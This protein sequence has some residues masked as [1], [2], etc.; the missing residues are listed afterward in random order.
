MNRLFRNISSN[1][2]AAGVHAVLVLLV[3]PVV[4][5]RLGLEHY[6]VWIVVQTIGYFLG[7][8]DLGLSDAQVRQ[9]A[10]LAARGDHQAVA[11]LHGTVLTLFAG[12][13]LLVV[14]L[15]AAI[16]ALPTAALLDIP[17]SARDSYGLVV[18]L[19]GLASAAA[20]LDVGFDGLF[21][22]HQ[23]YD[24]M[25]LVNLVVAVV[26]ALLVVGLLWLG[27]GLVALATLK[28]ITTLL[29]VTGKSLLARR[30]FPA[31][32]PVPG[33]DRGAW[34][35]VRGYTFW[36]SLNELA[37]EGT[38]H[39]DKLLI[40]MLLASALVTPYS[41]ICM[42]AAL[43]FALAE[44]ITSTFLPI[45]S[46]RHSRED[47]IGM[48]V[49]LLRGTRLVMTATVPAAVV[50]LFFGHAFLD[51][52]V[53]KEFTQVAMAVLWFTVANFL[54]STFLWTSL[55]LL[56]GAGR[57]RRVFE[58]S[59]MEVLLALGLVLVLT[60][61]LGLT[62]LA[63][64]GLLANVWAGLA[65]FVP[66]ACRLAGT[67]RGDFVA[68]ALLRPLLASLPACLVAFALL[69]WLSLDGWL[70]LLG[71]VAATGLSGL[72]ALLALSNTRWERLR[73]FA[74]LRGLWGH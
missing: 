44:P 6:A 61:A 39:L 14:L 45:A 62:G 74:V 51:L 35:S 70:Q 52:W 64:A 54:F 68:R 65:W 60:P 12:A 46:H 26:E 38:A 67:A 50:V 1:Y 40:P 22:G 53:G 24:L 18:L 49:L 25:N 48:A 34:R 36:N 32:F 57:M 58:L 16:A 41:L 9:H 69:Q 17:A 7:F 66:E 72:L 31:S 19:V 37:T 42:V 15:A 47:R 20:F 63:L 30:F 28:V 21:E 3:T 23:R 10:R 27:Y 55:N 2:A 13:G 11:R 4:V 8:L 59:V 5:G 33:F 73:Y 56:M 71:A 29:A 43:V